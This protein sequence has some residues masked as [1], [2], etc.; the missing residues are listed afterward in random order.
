MRLTIRERAFTPKMKITYPCT[1]RH[2]V[3]K[4]SAGSGKSER[5]AA[6]ILM[7]C[8]M[9]KNHRFVVWR[10]VGKSLR[11]S[12]YKLFQDLVKRW[13]ME[14]LFE[15]RSTEMT[16]TCKIN[17]NEI[18]HIGLDDA[19][20]IKSLT[21][22][23]GFWIEE[24]T[25][26]MEADY[27]QL[28]TRLRG[29]TDNYKQIISTFNPISEYHWIK[30]RFF[31]DYVENRTKEVG[32]ANSVK[33]LKIWDDSLKR[34]RVVRIHTLCVHSTYRD[35]Q[36]LD[37]EYKAT[38][39]SYKDIDEAYYKIYALGEWGSIGNLV[40]P[41]GFRFTNEYPLE[42]DEVIYGLD[43]GFNNP[44]ALVQVG[45]RDQEYYLEELFYEKGYTNAML[46]EDL[47]KLNL[48]DFATVYCDN[49]EPAR[50]KEL[51]DYFARNN[52]KV[53]F[54]PADK[55]VKDGLDAVRHARVYTKET[56]VQ[57]NKEVSSYKFKEGGDGK[58]L[59]D[60]QVVKLNDHFMDAVRYAI[61]TCQL[62]PEL[63]MGFV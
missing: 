35:N 50:I 7:R 38:L 42:Y 10:K 61:Y 52:K 49:A 54:L 37:D 20:K 51:N 33:E 45:I 15:F 34:D 25:E 5:A 8:L 17:G 27:N 47:L 22:P 43:F 56:N 3:E 46:C 24:V 29:H 13:Q 58:P 55:S 6:K 53:D 11:N 28:D 36:F 16:I 18:M 48:K 4:G 60:D 57:I 26:L 32:Y 1:S 14:D 19:E 62:A 41:K 2:L 31:D 23:T 21:M 63:K 39:E 40:Y 59:G 12:C 9:E 44:T 30:N